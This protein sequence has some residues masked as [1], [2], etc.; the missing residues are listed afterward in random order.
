MYIKRNMQFL[1]PNNISGP[2]TE[3]FLP[4]TTQAP[5]SK[6]MITDTL[7]M[8]ISPVT[9]ITADIDDT[10]EVIAG[11]S[12]PNFPPVIDCAG[13]LFMAHKEDCSKYLLCNFGQLSEQSCPN[14]LLWNEDRCDWPENTKCKN[15]R[16]V[17]Y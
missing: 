12:T 6:P 11:A 17:I 2:S 4:M 13:R 9:D 16:N 7:V 15:S 1:N 14:G 8:D 5:F 10:I 3:P